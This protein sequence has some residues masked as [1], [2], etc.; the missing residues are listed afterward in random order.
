MCS[1][2]A[3]VL[4]NMLGIYYGSQYGQETSECFVTYIR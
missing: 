4:A 2:F 3:G 1:Q